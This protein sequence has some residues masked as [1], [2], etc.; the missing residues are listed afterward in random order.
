MISTL[1]QL[2]ARSLVLGLSPWLRTD[3]ILAATLL[4]LVFASSAMLL[5]GYG[6]PAPERGSNA[7]H[8]PP[9]PSERAGGARR[10]RDFGT[11]GIVLGLLGC[12]TVLAICA[13]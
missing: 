7:D 10:G 12:L 6:S 3:L 4:F 5:T 11:F 1:Q 9:G 13:W 2:I 8:E